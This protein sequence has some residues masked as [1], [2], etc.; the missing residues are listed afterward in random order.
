M[1]TAQR[2]AF[3]EQGRRDF[4]KQVE[5]AK[6]Q[7]E[8]NQR[9]FLLDSAFGAMKPALNVEYFLRFKEL[10][11]F[12]GIEDKYVAEYRDWQTSGLLKAGKELRASGWIERIEKLPGDSAAKDYAIDIVLAIE[13]DDREKL[14][15]LLTDLPLLV[16]GNITD[17]VYTWLN[18]KLHRELRD[19]ESPAPPAPEP[20]EPE[21]SEIDRL[22]Q[23]TPPL[24]K[25]SGEWVIASKAAVLEDVD[26]E[27]LRSYRLQSKGG[28]KNDAGTF[29]IDKDGR[30]WRRTV[31]PAGRSGR[32]Y[33]LHS[34]LK[35]CR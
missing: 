30:V 19:R 7:R 15:E 4:A 2:K 5:E 33:Y 25:Q 34:T 35:G 3:T 31:G 16:A 27:S 21:L 26:T 6:K 8:K 20:V 12:G 17:Q 23:T 9:S 32:V 22:E 13:A 28:M 11:P 10:D 24:D 14:R 29:G 1:D 18:G